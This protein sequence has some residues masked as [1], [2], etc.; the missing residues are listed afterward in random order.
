MILGGF[1]PPFLFG[2]VMGQEL[3]YCKDW[4]DCVFGY[5]CTH[6]DEDLAD[7]LSLK[8]NPLLEDEVPED[9]EDFLCTCVGAKYLGSTRHGNY[10]RCINCGNEFES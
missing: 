5:T 6:N 3:F 4:E 1:M 2:E 7:Y 10:Y 8:M 9:C